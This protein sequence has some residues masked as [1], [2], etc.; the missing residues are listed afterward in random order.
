MWNSIDYSAATDGLSARLSRSILLS[1]I[2]DFDPRMKAMYRAVL[3]PHTCKYPFP[4]NEKVG[5]I[6]QQNGQLMGSILSFPILCL[7]NLGL[8]LANIRD[9]PRRLRRKLQGV[10]VNGDDMLYVARESRWNSHVSLGE[11]VGLKMSPGKAYRHP[12]YAN[13]NSACFHLD[14]PLS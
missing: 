5:D 6:D 1:I 9:D 13:A 7:A 11:R 12:V 10:L 4:F 2:R 8:Y 3:A 14:L